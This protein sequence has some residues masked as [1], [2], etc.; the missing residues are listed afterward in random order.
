MF[1]HGLKHSTQDFCDFCIFKET[2]LQK[3]MLAASS[4]S[5]IMYLEH[6][7][8]SALTNMSDQSNHPVHVDGF[9]IHV[10]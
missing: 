9:R 4:L 7:I 8:K 1:L 10:T 2:A 5:Q 6:T 3:K